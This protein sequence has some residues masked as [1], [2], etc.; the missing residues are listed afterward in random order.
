MKRVLR[1][2]L[3]IT[4]LVPIIFSLGCSFWNRRE[5]ITPNYY[6]LDY[7]AP[8]ENP[9]LV[10][11]THFNKTLEVMETRLPRTYDRNQI[12]QKKSF[13]Q[14]SYFA[15]ELWANKLYDAV[16]NLLVRRLNAYN[17]FKSVS[18]D[19][20]ESVPDYYL[21]TFIQNIE[22]VSSEKPY[23]FLRMD[24][25]L[26]DAKTQAVVFSNKSERAETLYD[27]SVQ[28][29]V[30]TFNEMIMG[31][32]DKFA[33]KSIDFLKGLS[34]KDSFK[35]LQTSQKETISYREEPVST[36]E[37]IDSNRGELM[38][39]LYL[40]S[41]NPI[42]YIAEY[43]D[44]VDI[45]QDVVTGT[46]NEVL[47]LHKG[48]W[49]ITMGSELDIKT[50]VE[51]NPHMRAVVAPFWSELIV[52]IIDESQTRVRMRYDIYSKTEGQNGF[53]AKVNSIY[54]PSDEIGETDYLWVINPGN[55]LITL[56]GA[57]P[58]AYKDFTTVSIDAGKSYVLTIVVDPSGERSVLIG[59]GIL[60]SSEFVEKSGFHKG[61]VHTNL[62][63]ASSN[64]VD[65]NNPTQSIS[66]S[67]QFDNKIDYDVW[68][69]HFTLKSLYDLGF[70]KT[71]GTEFR[72]NV[73]DYSAK[74]ALV[75]YPW[76]LNKLLKNFGF[77]GRGD[78]NT[79]FFDE[80]SFF[81]T[82]KNYMKISQ[83]SDTLLFVNAKKLKVKEPYYPLRLKEGC[84]LT[85][86]VNL[87][88]NIYFNLRSGYG[89]QQDYEKS[90][91]SYAGTTTIDTLTYE[92]YKENQPIDTQG[93][94]ASFLLSATN[95]FKFISITSN[96]DVLF[97]INEKEKSTI[98]DNENLINI[99]LYR[100]ISMDIKANIKYNKAVQDY[101]LTDYSAFLRLSLYY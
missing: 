76:K 60:E 11:T 55:Y 49:K 33:Q 3:I 74:N 69:F 43:R 47:S 34:V 42:P 83:D 89:W 13:T 79:H 7:L 18:R 82:E 10:Q 45:S 70:D 63:L 75:L 54:S 68:P 38:I 8:T 73:D 25:V 39:P 100:N 19:L 40:E 101:V 53:D 72:V 65:K 93:L 94:E 56:N 30:Q 67:G 15:N 50:T 48:K 80:Y 58:N 92:V 17:I 14:I 21:E 86:R 9:D 32:T 29:F 62:S 90:V 81:E 61:A 37:N 1:L 59:A 26:K 31:E 99:K 28:Y 36:D 87:S 44:T 20:G 46:M 84:G 96:L 6:V 97:P 91:Y 23:A 16:P 85:Y 78:I 2:T 77:Y 88:P 71:T 5:Y 4:I 27:T 98:F 22:Y 41:E 95:L 12:V 24:F 57:S 52:K 51:I 35:V 64:S 66:L